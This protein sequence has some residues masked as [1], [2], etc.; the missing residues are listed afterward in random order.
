MNIST[1]AFEQPR[2][3]RKITTGRILLGQHVKLCIWHVKLRQTIMQVVKSYST[4]KST[5]NTY[6]T[7]HDPTYGFKDTGIYILV[8]FLE[9]K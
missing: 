1:T 7:H 4:R 5:Q 2:H 6:A 9:F 3:A 8:Y